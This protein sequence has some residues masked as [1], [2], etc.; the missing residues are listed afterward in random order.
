MK[1]EDMEKLLDIDVLIMLLLSKYKEIK[2]RNI[3]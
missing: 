2:I 1:R 3:L